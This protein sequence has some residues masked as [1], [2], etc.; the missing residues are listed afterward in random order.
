[1]K[2]LLLAGGFGTRMYP[3]TVDRAKPLLKFRGKPLLTHIVDKIPPGVDIFVST[4][5]KFEADFRSWQQTV[6][7]PV[8]ICVE[9]A[10]SEDRKMGAMHSIDYWIKQKAI[11]EDLMVV[12]G[13]NYFE[14]D[15]SEYV[16]AFNGRDTLVAVYDIN[17][18]EMASHFGVVQLAGE[19]IVKIEEKPA[20]PESTVVATAC[21]IIPSRVLPV[22]ASYCAGHKRDNLGNFI[23]YLVHN[24]KV[25]GFLFSD[26]WFDVGSRPE[27]VSP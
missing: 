4:N 17:D 24:D 9:D 27:A 1:M 5:K 7:R 10:L 15:M 23:S 20:R 18:R 14:F 26:L 8:E 16:N 6:K 11:T 13:D 25:A 2:C 21:Y 19:R 12:G 3:L 22:C